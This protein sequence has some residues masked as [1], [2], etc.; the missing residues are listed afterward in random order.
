LTVRPEGAPAAHGRRDRG[1][2]TG[3]ERRADH[4]AERAPERRDLASLPPDGDR[5]DE[6]DRLARGSSS[7]GHGFVESIRANTVIQRIDLL[8]LEHLICARISPVVNSTA[9]PNDGSGAQSAVLPPLHQRDDCAPH[10][11]RVPMGTGV[12][13]A[14]GGC[15]LNV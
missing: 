6:L 3:G 15:H 11:V 4:A 7:A 8:E 2:G 12:P 13:P 1:R 9:A 14:S 5:P 10:A